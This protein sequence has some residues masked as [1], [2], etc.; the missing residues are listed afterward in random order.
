MTPIFYVR[1]LRPG[2]SL[3]CLGSLSEGVDALGLE[4]GFCC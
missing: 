4:P 2:V 3:T 1:K